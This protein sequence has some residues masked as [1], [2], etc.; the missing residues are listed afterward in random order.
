MIRT[1]FFLRKMPFEIGVF[2]VFFSNPFE[3]RHFLFCKFAG[4]ELYRFFM[5]KKTPLDMR[6][7]RPFN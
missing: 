7:S 6:S 3:A 4:A 5:K 2:G 1:S